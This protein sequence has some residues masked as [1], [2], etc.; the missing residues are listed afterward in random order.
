MMTETRTY[1][2]GATNEN[3]GKIEQDLEARNRLFI[4]KELFE[5]GEISKEEYVAVLKNAEAY[6]RK[7]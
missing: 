6:Y 2:A 5:L 4:A 3:I 7:R 1:I